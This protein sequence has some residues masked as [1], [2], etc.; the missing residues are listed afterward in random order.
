MRFDIERSLIWSDLRAVLEFFGAKVDV[1]DLHDGSVRVII[2]LR[3]G[4]VYNLA[5]DFCSLI[6]REASLDMLAS[7][8]NLAFFQEIA[9]RL[10]HRCIAYDQRNRLD[11][12]TPRIV[13]LSDTSSEPDME[14]EGSTLEEVRRKRV[15]PL[16]YKEQTGYPPVAKRRRKTVASLLGEAEYF[17]CKHCFK[18]F[19]RRSNMN[20]HIERTHSERIVF[21]CPQCPA[22]Y[23][24]AFHFAD[25]LRGHEDEPQFAC[26]SCEKQFCSRNELR[27]HIRRNCKEPH[28]KKNSETNS[29]R[30]RQ[31]DPQAG[32]SRSAS[33]S[34]SGWFHIPYDFP[35]T[36]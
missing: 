10:N 36:L 11:F 17:A 29:R 20:R 9:S 28:T 34:S 19:N 6:S 23:K 3:C 8:L 15:I 1:Q 12:K 30:S 18:S 7:L 35:V 5:M 33:A 13:L 24:H 22:V 21:T 16:P 4:N 31:Y 27:A 26:D 25:H 14:V 2:Q 32:A